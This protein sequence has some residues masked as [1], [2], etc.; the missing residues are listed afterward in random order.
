MD[1]CIHHFENTSTSSSHA[2]FR[3]DIFHSKTLLYSFCGRENDAKANK[4]YKLFSHFS[5]CLHYH[6]FIH[7]HIAYEHIHLAP[8]RYC[9]S[10]KYTHLFVKVCLIV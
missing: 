7:L 4:I 9:T 3:L 5:I 1:N 10:V 6:T 8:G 2:N